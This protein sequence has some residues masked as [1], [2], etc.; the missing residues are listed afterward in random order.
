MYS[1]SKEADS[2][3]GAS[4]EEKVIEIEVD[5]EE[6]E[7]VGDIYKKYLYEKLINKPLGMVEGDF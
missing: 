1:E 2:G 3:E 4:E 7:V 5:E 6:K